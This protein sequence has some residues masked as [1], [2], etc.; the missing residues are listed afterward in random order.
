MAVSNLRIATCAGCRN[1]QH[2]LPINNTNIELA[3]L[4]AAA[5][6]AAGTYHLCYEGPVS[7]ASISGL[8]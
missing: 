6:A 4:A 7:L 5:A 1:F 2:R 8:L 3:T